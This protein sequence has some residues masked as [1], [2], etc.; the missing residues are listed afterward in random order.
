MHI[1]FDGMAWRGSGDKDEPVEENA[2]V[3]GKG[4]A[5]GGRRE[6]M[7]SLEEKERVFIIETIK[8]RNLFYRNFFSFSFVS[9]KITSTVIENNGKRAQKKCETQAKRKN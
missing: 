3:R 6:Q 5:R 4:I 8:G 7:K 9:R 1:G 2:S